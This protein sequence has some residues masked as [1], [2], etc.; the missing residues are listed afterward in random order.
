[1]SLRLNTIINCINNMYYSLQV[2]ICAHP[3]EYIIAW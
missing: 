3:M 2:T 1:M